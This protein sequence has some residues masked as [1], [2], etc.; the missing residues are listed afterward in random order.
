M[1]KK[2]KTHKEP[3]LFEGISQHLSNRKLRILDDES[4]W[5]NQFFKQVTSKIDETPMQVLY[6]DR[7][8]RPNS[9]IR[10]LIAMQILKEGNGWTDEQLY[11]SCRFNLRVMRA[12]GLNNLNDEVPTES[13]YYDFKSRLTK[14]ME[15]S[16]EDLFSQVFQM[17]TKQQAEAFGVVGKWI[18]MDSKLFSSNIALCSRLQLVITVLQKFYKELEEESKKKLA[19]ADEAILE[20]LSTKKATGLVYGMNNEQKAQSLQDL[21][22]LLNRLKQDFDDTDSDSY[23][24]LVQLIQE[25]YEQNEDQILPKA[26]KDISGKTLQSVHD[27]QATFRK[28]ESGEKKQKVH[29]YCSNITETCSDQDLNLITDVQTESAATSDDK[30]VQP[31]YETTQSITGQIQAVWTDGSYNS[32]SNVQFFKE[33]EQPPAWHLNA[34]QGAKGYFEFERRA[35]GDLWVTNTRTGQSQKAHKTPSGKYRADNTPGLKDKYRYFE[36]KTVDNYFRRLEIEAQ[37]EDIRNRRANVESTI[38]HVFCSLNGNKSRYRGLSKNHMFVLCRCFWVNFKRISRH[39]AANPELFTPF[40][41]L[42]SLLALIG[43]NAIKK[44]NFFKTGMK[45]FI[46]PIHNLVLFHGHPE[47]TLFGVASLLQYSMRKSFLE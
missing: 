7:M 25:Q 22:E 44:W 8:G 30:Y 32:Q 42:R 10:Q 36:P 17:L 27:T 4:Q 41:A 3:N 14:H 38:N 15:K 24:L 39:L 18:R 19:A 21:G 2:S 29:G 34:L 26:K 47:K 5:H 31:A 11:E 40:F 33:L 13:S 9:P 28:K 23:G 45:S 35:N 46:N 20:E 16:G 6:S 12:L 43:A 37:P 1:F